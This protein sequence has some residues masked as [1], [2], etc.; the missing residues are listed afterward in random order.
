MRRYAAFALFAGILVAGLLIRLARVPELGIDPRWYT[1]GSLARELAQEKQTYDIVVNALGGVAGAFGVITEE[2]KSFLRAAFSRGE[3]EVLDQQPQLT[4]QMLS[5]ALQLLASKRPVPESP[6]QRPEP[7]TEALG[8]PTGKPGLTGQPYVKD[9]GNDFKWG[10]ELDPKKAA[11]AADSQRLADVLEGVALGW[12]SVEGFDMSRFPASFVETLTAQGHSIEVVDQRLAAN[13]GDLERR[14][15]PVA[16]PLWVITGKRTNGQPLM[17]PVPHAQLVLRIEGP[18]V[19]ADVTFYPSLDLAGDGSGGARFRADV[20]ADQAWTGGWLAHTYVKE[21]AVRA[22]ELMLLMRRE[23][24]AKVYAKKVPLDGYFELGVCTLA[25]AVV[26]Q[27][28]GGKTT[29]WPL[30]QDPALFDGAGELDAIVRALP[31]DGRDESVPSDERLKGSVPWKSPKDVPYKF[32]V[33][34]LTEL[35]LMEGT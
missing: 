28:L 25:P 34:E 19:N 8:L 4:L 27:A 20:T 29:L 33:R 10:D 6:P 22:L 24:E 18:K 21:Q 2:H 32:L 3:Y 1:L 23:L 5:Q 35:K 17:L 26:E 12:L 14:G 7:R 11:R 13:F 30:T 16:T 9:L 31:H 15:I